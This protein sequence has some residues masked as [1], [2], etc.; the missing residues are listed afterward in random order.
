MESFSTKPTILKPQLKAF[1]YYRLI[2]TS[3][4][5]LFIFVVA[6]F[7]VNAFIE[8]P[9]LYFFLPVILILAL[10]YISLSA[11]YKKEEY[12]IFPDRLV[13]KGGGIFSDFERELSV[14]NITHID[15]LLPFPEHKL[16]SI[17][18][19]KVESAGAMATEIYLR[20]IDNPK[21]VYEN[22]IN[23][24]QQN[25][26]MLKRQNLVQQERPHNLAVF[27]EVFKNFVLAIFIAAMIFGDLMEERSE[28]VARLL[29]SHTLIFVWGI[30]IFLTGLLINA[31]LQFL[32]LK[33][34]SYDLYDDAVV[35]SGGLFNIKYSIIPMENLSDSTVTQSFVSKIFNLYDVKLSCQ[36]SAQEIKFKNIANGELLSQNI[37]KLIAKTK[38]LSD[39][40]QKADSP[41]PSGISIDKPAKRKLE[42]DAAYT[43]EFRMN[44]LR[45][46]MPALLISP[47]LIIVFPA[48]IIVAIGIA[49]SI[50]NNVFRIRERSLEHTYSFLSR[51]TKEFSFDKV[52]GVIYKQGIIDRLLKTCSILFWSIGSGKNI[53]F[54]NIRK[55]QELKEKILAKKGIRPQN[56][57]YELQPGFNVA[58]ML[59]GNIYKSLFYLVL[60]ALALGFIGTIGQLPLIIL[61]IFLLIIFAYRKIYYN[62]SNLIFYEDYIYF[63]KGILS[64]EE[65]FVL[66]DDIKDIT[67]VQYPFSNKG[68]IVFN[69]AGETVTKT[70]QGE[71]R[72]SNAFAINYVGDITVLD[73]LIDTIFYKRPD[74]SK[75]EEIKAG[76]RN[77]SLAPLYK[78]TPLLASYLV[79]TFIGLVV[80]DIIIL[81]GVNFFA[82]TIT[83]SAYLVVFVLNTLIVSL[84]VISTKA[85]SYNMDSYRVY[86]RSG[87]VF[88]KQL[89]IIYDKIDFVNFTQGPTNKMFGNG[90]IT[91]NTAGSSKPEM[92]IGNI[93]DYRKFYEMLKEHYK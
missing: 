53:I 78:S 27:F 90:N 47:L 8:A 36:G 89:S 70:R 80:L 28:D 15:M 7:G 11:S 23:L 85:I 82:Y 1:L 37:D 60:V 50:K 44:A 18:Y 22:L 74:H 39:Q 83:N 87:I 3:I 31:F 35:Y 46:W 4:I 49:L 86:A 33:K 61:G 57:L 43:A 45:T 34:R 41:V 75:I 56:Q 32:D 93:K 48:G 14:E 65:Y 42:T 26:F 63:K 2:K 19:I 13:H 52:T 30:G 66:Y 71:C 9:F 73:E 59:M 92:V 54:K 64:K 55:K 67:T 79:P 38:S 24:M 69:V 25:G 40:Q 88:K 91:V 10:R 51:E 29:S 21:S 17:G 62:N 5:C 68:K 76:L 20:C 81:G 6:Y 72:R 77:T 84:I 16:F 12:I 58:N